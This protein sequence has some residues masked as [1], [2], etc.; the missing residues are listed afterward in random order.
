MFTGSEGYMRKMY[1][2]AMG[3]S[4]ADFGVLESRA[5]SLGPFI[6]YVELAK[7]S[8]EHLKKRSKFIWEVV[9]NQKRLEITERLGVDIRV[10]R[11]ILPYVVVNDDLVKLTK[12]HK[13][14]IPRLNRLRKYSR[15][16]NTNEGTEFSDLDLNQDDGWRLEIVDEEMTPFEWVHNRSARLISK[17][18][19]QW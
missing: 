9:E 1:L 12:N 11:T 10:R 2:Y 8:N 16:R 18:H 15:V 3:G 5:E 14:C 7:K 19:S 13:S 6:E 4:D 17:I